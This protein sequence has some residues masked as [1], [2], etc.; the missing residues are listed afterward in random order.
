MT[1]SPIKTAM[2]D[3]WPSPGSEEQARLTRRALHLMKELLSSPR[4]LSDDE[5]R[6]LQLSVAQSAIAN[7]RRA[8]TV[9]AH[10]NGLVPLDGVLQEI[11]AFGTVH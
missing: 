11:A 2:I 7:A 8:K 9:L 5:E 4:P 1:Q 3:E 10:F 6:D